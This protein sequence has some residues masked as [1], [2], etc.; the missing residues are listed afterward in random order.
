[1]WHWVFS[2]L[3]RFPSPGRM[4]IATFCADTSSLC[5]RR[6]SLSKKEK[7]K[8]K[9]KSSALIMFHCPELRVRVRACVRGCVVGLGGVQRKRAWGWALG[10]FAHVLT[11]DCAARAFSRRNDLPTKDLLWRCGCMVTGSFSTWTHI[12]E[13]PTAGRANKAVQQWLKVAASLVKPESSERL[14]L[15]LKAIECIWG[16]HA[17]KSG[18]MSTLKAKPWA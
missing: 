2:K 13:S 12:S 6:A 10:K 5:L 9:K 3:R 18:T 14:K 17:N 15:V 11:I 7:E 16:E 8:K 1:M 4:I